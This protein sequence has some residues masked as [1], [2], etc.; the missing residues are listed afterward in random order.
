MK[1]SV[2]VD[3]LE[4]RRG[5]ATTRVRLELALSTLVSRP[6]V[7]GVGTANPGRHVTT[8]RR[9]VCSELPTIGIKEA[10]KINSIKPD[11]MGSNRRRCVHVVAYLKCMI[12]ELADAI[13]TDS[14]EMVY[15]ELE[16][17]CFTQFK[18]NTFAFPRQAISLETRGRGDPAVNP[19]APHEGELG[20]IPGRVTPDFRMWETC[21]TMPLVGGF[22]RGSP[23]RPCL[24]V[25]ALLQ[26][27]LA[28]PLSP[29]KTTTLRAAQISSL[30]HSLTLDT[31]PK[32][33]EAV[34]NRSA[35][36]ERVL[37]PAVKRRKSASRPDTRPPRRA[38][39]RVSAPIV[40]DGDLP[41]LPSTFLTP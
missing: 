20:S 9:L 16:W 8:T 24:F 27:H 21:R 38:A 6:Q 10:Y 11:R 22:S 39:S 1:M 29:P 36:E 3:V 15:I 34:T 17:F 32:Y 33:K 35:G 28:S 14:V 7:L 40:S 26:T 30:T 41:S 5:A 23:V 19:L 13:R 25:P 12:Q 37:E 18:V 4:R 2:V 31:R